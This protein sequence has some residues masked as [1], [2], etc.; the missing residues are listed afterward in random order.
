[1]VP[2]FL[3]LAIRISINNRDL[4][5]HIAAHSLEGQAQLEL[6][7][8]EGDP[9]FQLI[10][11]LLQVGRQFGLLLA[12]RQLGFSLTSFNLRSHVASNGLQRP[13]QPLSQVLRGLLL[14]NS[15]YALQL[16]LEVH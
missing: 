14:H 11:V 3:F 2:S 9:L 4:P 16:L 13:R 5:L 10:Q 12:G 8:I 6:T 15:R 7:D 1:M